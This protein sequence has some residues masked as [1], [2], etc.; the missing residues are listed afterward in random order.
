MRVSYF[1]IITYGRIRKY[2]ENQIVVIGL[3][4]FGRFFA[5]RKTTTG[6][7]AAQIHATQNRVSLNLEKVT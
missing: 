7:R 3:A 5:C 1:L 2:Q 4:I 6:K